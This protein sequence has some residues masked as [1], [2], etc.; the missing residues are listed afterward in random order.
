MACVRYIIVC[1]GESEW[2]YIRRLQSFL[3]QQPLDNNVFETPLR[4]I[5]PQQAIAKGGRFG[6]LKKQY[7][8]TR[9][10]NKPT[11][12]IRIWADFD[13]YH[14][15]DKAA[16]DHYAKK[17]VGIPDFHFS[18]HNFEDFYALHLDDEPFQQWLHYGNQGHFTQPLHSLAYLPQFQTLV[19][20]YRKGELPSDII[21][22]TTLKNLKRN[23][24][25]QPSANPIP[26]EESTVSP[27]F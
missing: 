26:C 11:T 27:I 7:N 4:L 1:E 17:P 12:S 10:A 15:N 19:A 3:D 6:T 8:S 24:T 13:L 23:K 18:F 22:W 5:A 21:T 25:N 2:T 16:A 20:E 14:R 9:K